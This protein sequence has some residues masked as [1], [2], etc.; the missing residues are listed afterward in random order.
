MSNQYKYHIGPNGVICS[1][2]VTV[3]R[4]PNTVPVDNSPLIVYSSSKN[5]PLDFK[6][7]QIQ[8]FNSFEEEEVIPE[9]TNKSLNQNVE[10]YTY[11]DDSNYINV[12]TD[13]KY[14]YNN[15]QIANHII[16][17]NSFYTDYN[18]DS[19]VSIS[20]NAGVADYSDDKHKFRHKEM[21]VPLNIRN[22]IPRNYKNYNEDD[23]YNSNEYFQEDSYKF[24]PYSS[25][26]AEEFYN[27]GT[28]GNTSLRYTPRLSQKNQYN[29]KAIEQKEFNKNVLYK[30]YSLNYASDPNQISTN[31]SCPKKGTY[32]LYDKEGH[33]N[34]FNY[35][36]ANQISSKSALHSRHDCFNTPSKEFNNNINNEL[37]EQGYDP[38]YSLQA[39]AN[40]N[41]NNSLVS[42]KAGVL[43][44]PK[45]SYKPIKDGSNFETSNN[46]DTKQ[47]DHINVNKTRSWYY[48]QNKNDSPL[49]G[50]D[51]HYKLDI[52]GSNIGTNIFKT[53]IDNLTSN[54]SSNK[55]SL[56][57]LNT[58][59]Q[60]PQLRS[61]SIN[62][63]NNTRYNSLLSDN[64]P[65]PLNS[66][67]NRFD[68]CFNMESANSRPVNQKKS[69]LNNV[70]CK[71]TK[72]VTFKL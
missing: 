50:T 39:M 45:Y 13:D 21:H 14:Y 49:Y 43:Y 22:N 35:T 48:K 44:D 19:N 70:T 32:P 16:A 71:K 20:E 64:D 34:E 33:G 60:Y 52:S 5:L 63:T 38:L 47:S 23:V 51:R 15:E 28:S 1:D 26:R 57:L 8:G 37:R 4:I 27:S 31:L 3:F 30:R 10:N 6:S 53:V 61:K 18:N 9:Q 24:V 12:S 55:T 42:S 69:D 46:V 25:K 68:D 54:T 11:G 41:L 65:Y 40:K 2:K 67:Q 66:A 59:P 56:N 62:I 36:T 29:D 72:S 7:S 17:R 58:K